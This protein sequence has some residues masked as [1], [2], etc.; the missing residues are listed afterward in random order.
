MTQ[1]SIT[2]A[3]RRPEG[4]GRPGRWLGTLCSVLSCVPAII[5]AAPAAEKTEAEELVTL[6]PFVVQTDSDIGYSASQSVLGGRFKQ[7]I[8][9]IPSQIEVFTAEMIADFRI[10]SLSD[11]FRYSTN[12]E[13]LEEFVSPN[14]GGG[15]FWS[16][17]EV[18]RV[19]GIQPSSF[20][21]SR[22]LFSSITKTDA[23]NAER[24]EIGS[25]AQS[26]IFSL[27][28][29]SGV[30]NIKLKTAEMRNF[31]ST[32]MTVDSEDG[33]RFVLD[34][35]RRVLKDK[36]AIRFAYLN[37]N[38]PSFVKPSYDRNQRF[39]GA[40]TAKPLK[41]TT[42]RLH[43][44]FTD[45][46]ANLP[47]TQLPFDF[48]TPA[49]AG[50]RAGDV[51]NV[52][53][54]TFGAVANSAAF[55]GGNNSNPLAFFHASAYRIPTGPGA[56]AFDPA[57]FGPAARDPN[58]GAARV[59]FSPQNINLYPEAAAMVG[60]NFLGDGV[61]NGF[62]SKIFDL[63]VEQ[64]LLRSLSLEL[65]GHWE[66][67]KRLQQSYVGYNN[68]GY[69]A[70][71]NRIVAKLPWPTVRNVDSLVIPAV[72][73]AEYALNPNF[74]RLFTMGVPNGQK[75][76]EQ[77]KEA[78][79][80][81]AW[82]PETPKSMPWLGKHSFFA[83]YNYRDSFA[84]AQSVQVRLLGNLQYQNFNG[85]LNDA[86]RVFLYTHYFD[87]GPNITAQPPVVGGKVRSLEELLAG[88]VTFTEPTTGQVIELSGWNTPFGGSLPSGNT[89]QLGSGIFAWQGSFFR[90]LLLSYGLRDDA[91]ASK[92]MNVITGA[93]GGPNQVNGGW[94]FFDDP[95]F[96]AWNEATRASYRANSH[97][98][99]AVG[100]PLDWL[101]IS[102]YQSATFNL[103]TGQ[104]TSFGDPI[105]GTNGSSKE[106]ALRFDL[107]DGK[108]YLK[109]DRYEL[110]RIGSNVG[111]GTVRIEAGR[112]ETSYRRVVEDLANAR[113]TPRYAALVAQQG[114]SNPNAWT[115]DRDLN[116][117]FHP[118]TGDTFSKGYEL[119]AGTRF[120]NLDVR[121]TFA[122]A[123][124]LQGNVSKDW[125]NWVK[126]RVAIWSEPN[127]TD[128][129]GNRGWDRIPYQGDS[130]NN[131]TIRDANG[132]LRQM[133]MKE[134]YEGVTQAA[135]NAAL[136][137]NSKP[138]D[139]GRKY[140]LNLNAAYDFK[141][142]ALKGFRTGGAVRWRS[143]PILGFPAE[144]SG[145]VSGGFPV[146]Q[147][148]L[149]HPYFGKEDLN[150]DLFLA[151][152]GR[153]NDRFRY[154]VQLNARNLRTGDNSFLSTR[155]NAFGESIFTVIETPRS[156]ALSLDLMF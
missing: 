49:Y 87:A 39:Y 53:A 108:G 1:N 19:R 29:P 95:Q 15:A 54:A 148:D 144:S 52:A 117:A 17:K 16:G 77:T 126:A 33:H 123:E 10:T 152:S 137:L 119:T 72:M 75:N 107:P 156:Y 36:L 89:T 84:Q 67:W 60:K 38:R 30:A 73:P 98:Y 88:G 125:E 103:P 65:G 114:L 59:T 110:S 11:A 97:T 80:S 146:P 8:K 122:K 4:T 42:V 71:I 44:E 121:L 153:L 50:I 131:Y 14:D 31:G 70:D 150:F 100:R 7:E 78:R 104:F 74:G 93:N 34:L 92:S 135:L 116:S 28:E 45:E 139:A 115:A 133:T 86:R 142:G 12:V 120:G 21:T 5:A 43:A 151:Y 99:G 94:R 22:N 145:I 105:P 124:T 91:V 41:Q 37:D 85:L 62:K 113:G 82:E 130:A 9:D 63:F 64:R 134:V 51:R 129:A 23:Y 32:S 109:I 79:A 136:Q 40:I 101:S 118:I 112:M 58:S 56:I 3:H 13:N 102:Y 68:Y 48:A 147:I 149:D 35:N 128:L 138:V 20:S 18:G 46:K 127:L 83:S 155:V 24:F 140:R 55:P 66:E 27:G 47:P 154:R 81:L 76:R 57:R 25:G 111:F 96:V 2:P 132:T 26:L 90:R 106:H 6:S 61:R 69:T 143:A 141:Q